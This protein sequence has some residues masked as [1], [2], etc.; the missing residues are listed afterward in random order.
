MP[1][2][3]PA[4][5]KRSQIIAAV[6]EQQ[7]VI[8]AQ[9]QRIAAQQGQ[10]RMLTDAV[11]QFAVAAKVGHLA[12]F[13]PIVRAA[14]L[15]VQAD[16]ADHPSGAPATSTE[17]AK[18][19]QTTDDPTNP[20]AVP[21]EGNKDVTPQG[22]TDLENSNVSVNP[23]VLDNLQDVTKPVSGTDAVHPDAAKVRGDVSVGTPSQDTLNKGDGWK[24]SSVE[25]QQERFTASVRLA[26]LRMQAGLVD[27]SEGDDFAVG[28]R[29]A[30]STDT[31]E[32]IKAQAETLVSVARR[33]P[34]VPA[35]QRRHLVPRA[36]A[37]SQ[38][39]Q[40]SMQSQASAPARTGEDEWAFGDVDS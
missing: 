40:P 26:R 32:S 27:Q 28:Q 31:L 11:G 39:I 18:K 16:S 37:A 3:N 23:P 8:E 2:Q 1:E 13:A 19:P 33:S 7:E 10:I 22:V 25:E 35:E 36:A 20:G 30:R 15:R 38:G 24:T 21:S 12:P 14:G 34:T 9:S 6:L 5:K 29:I 4:Q 17:E